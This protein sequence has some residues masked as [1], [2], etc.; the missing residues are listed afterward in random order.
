MVALEGHSLTRTPTWRKSTS[1]SNIKNGSYRL[2]M[3]LKA[4]SILLLCLSSLHVVGQ[5]QVAGT[6]LSREDSTFIGECVVYLDNGQET[7][8]TD[9]RGRFSFT[10]VTNGRH[11]LHFMSEEFEYTALP[12]TVDDHDKVLR[13]HLVPRLQT[14]SEVMVT[15]AQSGFGFTRLRPVESMGIYEGKKSEVIIPEQLVANL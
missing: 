2:K 12:V 14:L 15:D 5:H 13:V 6:V 8:T 7:A 1:R 11:T 4:F 10:A 9:A 3:K